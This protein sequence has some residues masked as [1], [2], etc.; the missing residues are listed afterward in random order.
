MKKGKEK[1]AM[2]KTA[3]TKRIF[4]KGQTHDAFRYYCLSAP[5]TC[6]PGASTSFMIDRPGVRFSRSLANKPTEKAM[7]MASAILRMNGVSSVIIGGYVLRVNISG[8]F[9]WND[10]HD[11]IIALLNREFF[12]GKAEVQETLVDMA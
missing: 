1:A 12:Q 6:C 3:K 2:T 9:N 11:A 8:A 7:H 4:W 10:F 5:L